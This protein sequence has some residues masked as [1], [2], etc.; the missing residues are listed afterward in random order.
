MRGAWRKY[1]VATISKLLKITGL[2]LQKSPIKGNVFL[3]KTRVI[4][5]S[6]LIIATAY[7]FEKLF[8]KLHG[9]H[10]AWRSEGVAYT[11]K[12]GAKSKGVCVEKGT[13]YRVC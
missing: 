1:G 9:V 7:N 2:F 13:Q 4:V 8:E 11:L 12:I 10:F 5:R 6:L 3:Q